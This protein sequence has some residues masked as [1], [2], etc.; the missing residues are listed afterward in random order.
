MWNIGGAVEYSSVCGIDIEISYYRECHL[1]FLFF[2][3]LDIDTIC[4]AV[5][6]SKKLR[7]RGRYANGTCLLFSDV[8]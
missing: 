3:T 2:S 8:C 1:I 5:A 4:T 7:R 6:R